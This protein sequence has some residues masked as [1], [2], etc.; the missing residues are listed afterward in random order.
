[1]D[2]AGKVCI[3]FSKPYVAKYSANG[4]VVSY[5]QGQ[6]LARGVSVAVNPTVADAN[7]FYADN[8]TAET[9]AGIF[10]GGTATLTV[11]GLYQEAEQMIQ[12]L[13][14]PDSDG[15]I[16]Y[17]DDQELPFL[18]FGFIVEFLSGGIR[19][20]TPYILPKT[21]ANPRT[22]EAETEGESVSFQTQALDL[23]L[24]RDDSAHHRWLRVGGDLT[25]EAAAEAKIKSVFGIVDPTPDP[26]PD[27]SQSSSESASES[28]STQNSEN[29]GG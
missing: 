10:T 5:S 3:G 8:V 6:K 13:S 9:L 24:M 26:D 19:Y 4:G 27:D 11:D 2:P 7:N 17:G 25:T 22:I 14:A 1:M 28:D 18:G 16:N 29:V 21:T 20:W 15:F 12:G 23:N